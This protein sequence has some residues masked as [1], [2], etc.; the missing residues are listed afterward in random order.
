MELE[1]EA[2]TEQ[3]DAKE[4]EEETGREQ[5]EGGYECKR[6]G[7]LQRVGPTMTWHLLLLDWDIFAVRGPG[8]DRDITRQRNHERHYVDCFIYFFITWDVKINK[9]MSYLIIRVFFLLRCYGRRGWGRDAARV[10]DNFISFEGLWVEIG[11]S[12]IRDNSDNLNLKKKKTEGNYTHFS[13]LT[14]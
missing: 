8:T 6:R 7:L 4:S 1:E 2:E 3:R 14:I 9:L 5:K 13:F 12:E 10:V 11:E